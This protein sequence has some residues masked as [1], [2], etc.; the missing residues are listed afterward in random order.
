MD[1]PAT[2]KEQKN[3]PRKLTE[4]ELKWRSDRLDKIHAW[5]DNTKY[6]DFI[7]D[8]EIETTVLDNAKPER[9]RILDI[10]DHAKANATTGDMLPP[11][12]VA[13]LANTTDPDLIEAIMDAATWIKET[14]YGNRIVL[15]APLYLS[16]P[17]VNNCAYCGFRHTNESV[18]EHTIAEDELVQEVHALEDTGHKRLVAVYGEHPTSDYLYIAKTIDKI[19][20]IHKGNGEIRRV[21]VNAAPQ[22]TDEYRIIKQVGIGTY[23]IFQET[24][25]HNAYSRVH[26]K[27]TLKGD[28]MWR[29][30]GQHRCLE[31]GIDDV[32]IGVLFGLSDWRFELLGLLKHAMALEADYG[33]G[34]HTISYPRLVHAEGTPLSDKSP[35]LVS[36]E[37]FLKLVAIIRLMVPY[38]GSILTARERKEIRRT[39][40]KRCGVSQTDAGT[41]IAVGGYRRAQQ[42]NILDEAQ[43]TINDPRNLDEFIYDLLEDGMLPS[44]CT[45]GYRV[46]RTGANFMP[47]AK[48]AHIKNFCVANGVLTLKEYILDYGSE[49][50]R[51]FAE[52]RTIPQYLSWIAENA[53]DMLDDTKRN[54]KLLEETSQRDFYF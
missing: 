48:H 14:V 13:A 16:S 39:A 24:Y 31:A 33:V 5:S 26:P 30:F 32:A 15:F 44:F 47:L 19:Y 53:P 6:R 7:D 38:T 21:N 46:G 3:S 4:S 54:L 29:L 40:I 10:I 20:S 17:C 51:N 41:R 42:E 23:Q 52:S 25:H 18:F 9:A 35:Y 50:V 1:N 11:A 34:P 2:A 27:N 22:F 37:D 49:L 12:D 45:A 28:F 8:A 36:D 43:F